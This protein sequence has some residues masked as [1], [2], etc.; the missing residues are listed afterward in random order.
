[1]H[2]DDQPPGGLLSKVVKFVRNPTLNWSDLDQGEDRES[3]YSKHVLKEM[4]ERKRANDFVRKRE[5]DQLR[6]LRQRGAHGGQ[7][8]SLSSEAESF[9]DDSQPGEPG[10]REGTLKKIDEI[11]A[12]MAHQWP[13]GQGR[14]RPAAASEFAAT[15]NSALPHAETP[16]T[17]FA[18]TDV[19]PP[20]ERPDR[21]EAAPVE[22]MLP[23]VDW[24]FGA[25]AD[26]ALV[27]D[28]ALEEA[29][30]RFANGDDAGAEASLL[31]LLGDVAQAPAQQR[32]WAALFDLYRATG[33]KPRFDA[34]AIDYAARCQ[35][36]A[37]AWHSI[38]D[39][40]GQGA[41]AAPVAH[42]AL[43]WSSPPV[44]GANEV[45]ALAS[46]VAER[47]PGLVELDWSPLIALTA[48]ALAPLT[49]LLAEWAGQQ[50]RV[51]CTGTTRLDR[52]LREH[53][54]SDR[55]EVP[56][57]WWRLR[58]AW[59]RLAHRPEEFDLVALDYCITYEVAPPAWDAPNC[60]FSST[61]FDACPPAMTPAPAAA[62]ALRGVV[63]GDVSAL[64]AAFAE[65]AQPDG[66]IQVD[67]HA[68]VRIDF[69]AA[70]SVLNWAAAQQAAGR[71]V[72]FHGLH[73][74]VAVFLH[75]IGVPDHAKIQL[76]R[77]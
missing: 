39:Q 61:G 35:R 45:A 7:P 12:Q 37:P 38:V 59:L 77:G 41:A 74:L 70:G 63:L 36:P 25:E 31:A 60:S 30:I 47:R 26:A 46:Q 43:N 55:R 62:G 57:D 10:Q 65:R 21:G 19:M 71:Q 28:P 13:R 24:S 32:A 14:D 66:Q 17:D 16:L 49:R 58:L 56:D 29:A 9:F 20:S 22:D 5:F 64:L 72:Q 18:A 53:T 33:Q 11:E 40:A 54:V 8:Q 52:L 27:A 1:M 73:R 3:T 68:L 23:G 4:I 2:Q 48:D 50:V 69:A 42:V 6:K 34:M 51:A 67:G 44:L 15:V 76:R 75:V